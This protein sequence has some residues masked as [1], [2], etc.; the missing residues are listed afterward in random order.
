MGEDILPFSKVVINIFDSIKTENAKK[1][2]NIHDEWGKILKGI[3]TKSVN[4]SLKDGEN[5]SYHSRVVDLKKGILFI[6]VDHPGWIEILN[7]HRQYILIKMRK[8]FPKIEFK[9]LAFLLK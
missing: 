3:K 5:L 8:K 6:E 4:S 2:V 9:T 1:S 7:V